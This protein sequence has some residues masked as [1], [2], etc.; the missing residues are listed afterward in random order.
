[1]TFLSF[2]LAIVRDRIFAQNF[3]AGEFLDIY[4]AA[5]R[6]PDMLF[7]LTT[8]LVSVYALL[9]VFEQKR[10]TSDESLKSFIDTIFYL[11]SLMLVIGA[12]VLF[13][14][15]PFIL[16][17]LYTGFSPEA[18][19]NLILFSRIFILQAG[20]LGLSNFVTTFIKM[21]KKF[22]I[23]AISPIMYNVGIIVGAVFLYPIWGAQGV[24][25]G[26]LLGAFL[27]LAVQV[28]SMLK[29]GIHP[30]L[31]PT[32]SDLK[33]AFS[34]IAIS[35]PRSFAISS[36]LVVHLFLFAFLVGI[37]E[38]I[39]TIYVFADN[40]R[41]APFSLIAL[42]Y[43]IAIFPSIAEDATN[44]DMDAFRDK[45]HKVM[46]HVSFFLL[47]TV[48]FLIVAREEVTGVIFNTGKFTEV[49]THTTAT[50]FG[51]LLIGILAAG[52]YAVNARALYSLKKTKEVFFI[53]L[54]SVVLKISIIYSLIRFE[55]A[56]QKISEIFAN[57]GVDST[58][59]AL[60]MV[61]ASVL[62][63]FDWLE[64]IAIT[65]FSRMQSVLYIKEAF[66]SIHEQLLAALLFGLVSHVVISSAPF[67]EG[68]IS[69][70]GTIFLAGFIGGFVW[71]VFLLFTKNREAKE[72]FT[73]ICSYGKHS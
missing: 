43:A 63:L 15:S 32:Y 73:R 44:K 22:F 41:W 11:F 24:L 70:V 29:V 50:V 40:L 38:G 28:P 55:N 5:F 42:S 8:S 54:S 59:L 45:M 66:G 25:A 49:T 14:I 13:F 52:I 69:T 56:T 10:Y 21:H 2:V 9:P 35:L 17:N 7:I 23:Y 47:P 37:G 68:V 64:S 1:M 48:I 34:T 33:E 4:F 12:V 71:F 72:I 19:E 20:L 46:R 30:R 26:V 16:S 53:S 3:G 27:H 18:L 65:I 6:L 39:L 62:V 57:F 61:I 60:L 67:G 51:I 31:H 36:H 58:Q